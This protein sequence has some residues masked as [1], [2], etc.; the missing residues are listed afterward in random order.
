MFFFLAFNR[1]ESQSIIINEIMF[2]PQNSEPE[3]IELL[4]I[5]DEILINDSLSITDPSHSYHFVLN[6][7]NPN[8]YCVL[9]KDTNLLKNY[10]KIPDSTL[11]IQTK[12]PSLNNDSDSLFL[13]TSQGIIIDTFFY[14]GKYAPKGFSIERINPKLPANSSQNLA[15][16]LS[17]DSAT[18]GTINSYSIEEPKDSTINNEIDISGNPFSPNSINGK[19]KC[20]ITL[21]FPHKVKSLNIKIYDMNGNQVRNLAENLSMNSY[22]TYKY[23]WDGTNENGFIL[24]VGIYPLII[25]YEKDDIGPSYQLTYSKLIVLGN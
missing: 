17:K 20:E 8:Q 25:T 11:L 4:N 6:T 1:L 10:R 2:N 3:W 13:S 14:S 21:K 19:N 15:K 7:L 23:E 22:E 5:S 24:Q 9:V 16:S 12:I 18:C